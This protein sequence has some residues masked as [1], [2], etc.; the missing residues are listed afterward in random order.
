VR[1][2]G[3]T[4]TELLTVIAIIAIVVSIGLGVLPRLAKRN[5][6]E[7]SASA[8]RSLIRRARNAAREEGSPARVEI[9]AKERQVRACG[10]STIA[11]FRF[12]AD[13]RDADAPGLPDPAEKKPRERPKWD[14]RG[15]GGLVAHVEGAYVD[16]GRIG[17]GLT[18]EVFDGGHAWVEDRPA[19]WA[20]D[21]VW[22][23]AWI[24][25]PEAGLEEKL[26]KRK[27]DRD[28]GD[29]PRW[30]QD[31][32]KRAGDPPRPAPPRL[33]KYDPN[34][35]PLFSVA[36][37]GKAFELA[38]TAGY[39]VEL[40]FT[41]PNERGE[42]R[43]YT[44]RTEDD[45]L[46]PR[47]WHHVAGSFDGRFPLAVIDGVPRTLFPSFDR[48]K[49]PLSLV[50]DT[51]PLEVSDPD[52]ERGFYGRIDELRYAAWT[53]AEPFEVPKDIALLAPVSEIDFDALGALDPLVHQDPVVL[54]LS[55]DPEAL[56]AGEPPTETLQTRERHR[57]PDADRLTADPEKA[58][59]VAALARKLGDRAQRVTVELAGTVR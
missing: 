3:Y 21:G 20:Q 1:S 26:R 7:A 50:R 32:V 31:A 18:F 59:K 24:W 35:P 34:K 37:K 16:E 42:E 4:L 49:H 15:S 13:Q 44:G 46:R 29:V 9:D 23:E 55:N 28:A 51:A 19:L 10:R 58:A 2:R 8:V 5:E 25:I 41:G 56:A 45:V 22:I 40:S 54:W 14:V 52:V 43:T 33:E 48:Q 12:E 36:R 11:L 47:T 39:A 38:V 17:D 6:L 27:N 53:R 57:E 30:M